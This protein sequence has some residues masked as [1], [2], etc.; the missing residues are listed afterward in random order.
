MTAPVEVVSMS[1]GLAFWVASCLAHHSSAWIALV[2]SG[3]L[4]VLCVLIFVV[5]QHV[6]LQIRLFFFQDQLLPLKT[7]CVSYSQDTSFL[8]FIYVTL[9]PGYPAFCVSQLA[10]N[11]KD[12]HGVSPTDEHAASYALC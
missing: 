11:G 10:G 5:S 7:H 2:Q 9:L 8:F 6:S 4:V 1:P 12:L 3:S